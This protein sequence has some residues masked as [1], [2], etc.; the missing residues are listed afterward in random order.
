[1]S[2]K[3]R[4]KTTT[5][6]STINDALKPYFGISS[7][8]L[9][10]M[11][12]YVQ[13]CSDEIGWFFIVKKDT[14]EKNLYYINECYLFDQ[15]VHAT[16]T[17]VNGENLSKFAEEIM[18][19]PNWEEIWNNLKGWGHSHVNMGV[20]PSG[21][22]D[23][24]MEFFANSQFD[25]FVRIIANK[26]GEL[27]VDLYDYVNGI[28]FIDVPWVEYPSEDEIEIVKEIRK[29]QDFINAKR[30]K[31]EKEM[32]EKI[33]KEITQ[34]V[35]KL[36]TTPTYSHPNSQY[37]QGNYHQQ[38]QNFGTRGKDNTEDFSKG[39]TGKNDS[40]VVPMTKAE[41]RDKKKEETKGNISPIEAVKL[42]MSCGSIA[43]GKEVFTYDELLELGSTTTR[44]MFH[45]L[46]Q[47]MRPKFQIKQDDL[48]Y[49]VSVATILEEA[50]FE[51][52]NKY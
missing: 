23:S 7:N 2:F 47:E 12:T 21:Q 24:Q 27:K 34:K 4:E 28:K 40:V 3:Q 14:Q 32:E 37:Y 41:R 8:A 22:D 17:E 48:N 13:K 36:V 51:M 29:L 11:K 44:K 39:A 5:T 19:L 6:V 33:G 46:L 1:M 15:E 50:H 49:L 9:I 35:R 30:Q 38:A 43:I 25:F 10:Q 26:S 16:T 45:I 42:V 18:Q 20:T 52:Y 31:K